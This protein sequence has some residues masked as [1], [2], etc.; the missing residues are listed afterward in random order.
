MPMFLSLTDKIFAVILSFLNLTEILGTLVIPLCSAQESPTPGFRYT[1]VN[2][3]SLLQNPLD[4]PS[5]N[6]RK[7]LTS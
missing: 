3:F 7:S 6:S 2:L 5:Q 4:L 1:L